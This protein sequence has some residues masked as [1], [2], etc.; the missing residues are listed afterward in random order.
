MIEG[1]LHVLS[2]YVADLSFLF[3][4]SNGD[5]EAPGLLACHEV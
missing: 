4:L 2:S 1:C 3:Y 5:S